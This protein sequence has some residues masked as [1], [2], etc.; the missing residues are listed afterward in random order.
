M[1]T[2]KEFDVKAKLIENVKCHVKQIMEMVAA[3]KTISIDFLCVTNLCMS[4]E[5]CVHYGLRRKIFG[6]LKTKSSTFALLH[7]IAKH[8]PDAAYVITKVAHYWYVQKETA[9]QTRISIK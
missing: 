1:T 5:S 3:S 8:C 7:K 2:L 4:I 9:Q 6:L